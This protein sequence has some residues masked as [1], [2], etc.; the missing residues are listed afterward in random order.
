MNDIEPQQPAWLRGLK[1][2][3]VLSAIYFAVDIALNRFAF[4]D[5]W[6]IIW[7]LNGVNVALLLMCPRAQWLWLLL[8]IEIGTGAG[9]IFDTSPFGSAMEVC[10]RLA[11][12]TEV[13]ISA[14]LLPPFS[15]LDQW[16]RT[17]RIFV[18]F[19]LALLLG[20]GV[21]GVMAAFLFNYAADQPFL[22]AFNGWA[23]ADAI[24]MAT[25]MPLSLALNSPQMHALFERAAL[26]KTLGTL[27]VALSGAMLIFSVSDYPLIFLLYPLLL[28]VDSLLFFAGS[29]L[30]VVAVCLIAMYF[31]TLGIGPFGKWSNDLELPRGLA[32]QIYFGFHLVALFPASVMFMERRRMAQEL[33]DTNARLTVLASLD[34]LTCIPNRRSFD[35]RFATEWNRA[36]RQRTPLALAMIDIDNF[37]Q[38]NDLY[39]HLAGDRCLRAVAEVLTQQ[40]QRPEDMAA[41]FGG[42]EFAFLLPHTGSEGAALVAERIR[43]AIADQGLEHIGNN[44]SHVTVSIGY[45]AVI[46]T[47]A[48]GQAGLL[49]LADAALYHAKRSGRNR[50]E[51]IT[52]I[53]GLGAA[54]ERASTTSKNRLMRLITRP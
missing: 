34:G 31:T 9:E 15:T 21:S 18:R 16:L 43:K 44:W 27:C 26:P 29:A 6:T 54:H 8:G 51:T 42:E 19:A 12:A 2:A 46:P 1:S 38:Y 24:G 48:D 35:E 32:L 3:L 45:S 11:S 13:L 22:I 53:E 23:T 36:V 49:Q 14:L 47:H 50:I 41:R 10:Q 39:G 30:V 28:L 5:G 17:P 20:P 25:T 40:I 52:S 37:K 7:P 33:R 4:S